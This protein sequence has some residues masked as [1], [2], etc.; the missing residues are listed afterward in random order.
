MSDET[1]DTEQAQRAFA[2]F[3]A[4]MG[5]LSKYVQP[6]FTMLIDQYRHTT[7][8]GKVDFKKSVSSAFTT[9]SIMVVAFTV[10]IPILGYVAT[11]PQVASSA[12]AVFA[13]QLFIQVGTSYINGPTLDTTPNQP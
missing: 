4:L 11:I 8:V 1:K 6:A 13:I 5:F 7:P 3:V 2:A 12:S 9:T 10:L